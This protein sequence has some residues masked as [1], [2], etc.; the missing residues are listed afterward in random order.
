MPRSQLTEV[1]KRVRGMVEYVRENLNPGEY[2]LFLDEIAPLEESEDA[3]Q[4]EAED[5]KA[6]QPPTCKFVFPDGE[7]C[8]LFEDREIHGTG[9]SQ[10]KFQV[11]KSR[12]KKALPDSVGQRVAED[13][14]KARDIQPGECVQCPH[15][16]DA[17]V[18][19]LAST[20]GFHDFKE[21][22]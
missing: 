11:R 19:H 5:K 14:K 22:A 18:H 2:E 21:A 13:V 16:P 6:S 3:K 1:I 17:N 15:P 4:P 7:R 8:G 10:H 12:T 20:P 9:P